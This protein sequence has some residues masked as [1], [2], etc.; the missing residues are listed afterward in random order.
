MRT[1]IGRNGHIWEERD[2]RVYD[3]MMLPLETSVTMAS[4]SGPRYIAEALDDP[5]A[6]WN[7]GVM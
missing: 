4:Y 3:T 6:P 5:D 2:G 1:F 7:G